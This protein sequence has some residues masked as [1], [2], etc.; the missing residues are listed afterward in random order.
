[1]TQ[2]KV[3]E[4]KMNNKL[5]VFLSVLSLAAA[6]IAC[7]APSV[8]PT[9]AAVPVEPQV[10]PFAGMWMSETETLVFTPKNL[11]RVES[12][13]ET[14]QSTEQFAEIIAQDDIHQ[15]ITLQIQ[16]VKVNGVAVGFDSPIYSLSYK[17]DGDVL[18]IGLGTANEFTSEL[19]PT[20]Y[21]RK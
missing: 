19:S 1:V 17:V 4:G 12:N 20:I 16:W 14:S 7:S 9:P 11:Y 8:T 21:Y 10:S 13:S 3:D 6:M 5:I 15:R 18:Q 2:P